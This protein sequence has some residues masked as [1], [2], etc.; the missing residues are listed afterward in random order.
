MFNT[1]SGSLQ[2]P[3]GWLDQVQNGQ[4]HL[5]PLEK[6]A[7]VTTYDQFFMTSNANVILVIEK[8]NSRVA[9]CFNSSV[10]RTYLGAYNY[11]DSHSRS[12]WMSYNWLCT[13][14]GDAGEYAGVPACSGLSSGS[15]PFTY[16]LDLDRTNNFSSCGMR[17]KF[18][19]LEIT[20]DSCLSQKVE[21]RCTVE[22]NIYFLSIVIAFISSKAIIMLWMLKFLQEK[23]LVVLGDAIASFV[24][25]PDS[26]TVGA[27][28]GPPSMFR[29]H[30][31][32]QGVREWQP[33]PRKWAA[34]ASVS[35]WMVC[36]GL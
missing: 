27:C 36:L 16:S 28:L 8:N 7:C 5:T 9:D 24:S 26:A 19:K 14:D 1:V 13:N 6:K 17:H 34:A 20:I 31:N 32:W 29:H 25:R 30:N 22:A 23:P 18:D 11:S 2:P 12:T 33:R 21:E 4:I 10:L 15:L 35:Q 3:T